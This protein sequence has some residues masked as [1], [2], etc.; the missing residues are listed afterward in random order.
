MTET[1]RN[2]R[3]KHWLMWRDA[4]VARERFNP[5]KGVSGNGLAR[6]KQA[7]AALNRCS[8][9]EAARVIADHAGGY[10]VHTHADGRIFVE[11]GDWIRASGSWMTREEA[12]EAWRASRAA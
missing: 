10:V 9:D 4:K 1:E 3:E 7:R 11:C 6:L 8:P 2:A 12:R 5:L